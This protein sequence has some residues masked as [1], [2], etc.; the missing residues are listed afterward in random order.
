MSQVDGCSMCQ[1]PIFAEIGSEH[2]RKI[3]EL[4]VSTAVLN[5]NW[6]FYRGSALL[7][8]RGHETELHEL[9]PD[10][11]HRFSDDASRIAEAI[12]K[13]FQPLKMNHALLGNAMAHLHWHL[14]PRR[15]T[16]PRPT[17]SIWEDEIPRLELS[18]EEFQQMASEIRG[19]LKA[20]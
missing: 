1:D 19:N 7:V 17:F 16:D 20:S 15:L 13:T 10:L 12:N 9:T 5:Q 8:L 11:R 4:D 18:D 14:I 3:A 2:P 6:Q